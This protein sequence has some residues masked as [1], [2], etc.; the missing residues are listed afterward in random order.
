MVEEEI[1]K[2][3]PE[4]QMRCPVHLSIGQEAAAVGVCSALRTTD[5][6]FSGHRNHAHYLAKGGNLRAMLAEI[7]GKATGCCGGKGGSMHLTDQSAGFIGATPIVGSTVPIAVGAALTAQREGNGRVVVVFLGDGAMEAG[8]VHESLNFAALK[9]LPILFACENNLYS[10]YSPLNVRQP[11]Q[12]SISGVAAGHG[13]KTIYVDGNHVQQVYAEACSAIHELRQGAGPVFMELPTYRWLEHCGPGYDN[14]IGYRTEEEFQEWKQRD[15]LRVASKQSAIELDAAEI[16]AIRIE[17]EDAFLAAIGDPFP[18]PATAGMHVYA[19]S[20][21]PRPPLEKGDREITYAEALREAQDICL[22]K[23]SNSYLM[24]LGVPDPKGIFGTTLGLQDRYGEERVFDIP[25]AEN[26]MTGVA[27]GSAI[28]GMRPILTHQRLDFAL[29]SI[30]Q[31]VNQAAKW[32]YMFNGLMNVPLVIRMI[33]GRGWGQGPQHS[34]SLHA[35]FAHI[36]GLK[37]IM[38]ST[39]YDAKGL[40]ISAIEENSPILFLEHRWL[41]G[42]KDYVPESYYT[43]PTEK[44]RVL[45]AGSDISLISLSYMTLECLKAAEL[46]KSYNVNAEVVDLIS[47][48]PIDIDTILT[49]VSRTGRCLMVDH[50]DP[51]CSLSSEVIATISE[52]AFYTFKSSPSR[53]TLPVHPAPTSY[54]LAHSYYPTAIDIASKV[55]DMLGIY[56]DKPIDTIGSCDLKDQPN[57]SFNGPF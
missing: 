21:T 44:A 8:V 27:I 39:P 37:V 51:M 54:H 55:L 41:H 5:W 40:L 29:V 43:L 30:D 32:H 47:I 38:P 31:I 26:A 20:I 13:V 15:P 10:V 2:R 7:Y 1:A 46:L 11:A 50:G 36:P 24:G 53:L 49:S 57:K 34:Q 48:R 56:T 28:T 9:Q 23:Y 45:K 3:Y 16:N 12:R 17:I 25:L 4:Q 33:I 18:D 42:I 19:P 22:A 6:A 35:W 52:L 14:D